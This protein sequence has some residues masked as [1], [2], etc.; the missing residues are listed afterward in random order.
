MIFI[1]NITILGYKIAHFLSGAK[2]L[3]FLHPHNNAHY[4]KVS[5]Y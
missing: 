2:L 3:L 5:D 4:E 1:K